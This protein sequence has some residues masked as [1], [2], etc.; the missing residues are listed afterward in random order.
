M[1]RISEL[2]MLPFGLDSPCVKCGSPGDVHR[3]RTATHYVRNGE[4]QY[5]DVSFPSRGELVEHL[6]IRCHSCGWE[7]LMEPKDSNQWP[8]EGS[9]LTAKGDNK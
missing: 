9:H 5:V 2:E 3:Y 4:G 1:S 7:W 6:V 8:A